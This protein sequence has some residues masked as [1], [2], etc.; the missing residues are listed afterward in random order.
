MED[1]ISKNQGVMTTNVNN[2][3]VT[4]DMLREWL[5]NGEPV[6]VLDIR[7]ADQRKEW[8]I[9]GSHYFDAYKRLNEGDYAVM[10]EIDIPA[11]TKV[12]TVCAAGRT[13]RIASELLKQ[14]GIEAYSLEG[15]MKKWSMAW[16]TAVR[17]FND[18][19]V[20]QVRRTGKGCLSYIISSK[21]EAVLLDASLPPDVYQHLIRKH[22]LTLKYVIETH[23]HADHLSRS[24]MLAEFYNVPL[25]LPVPNKVQ[26]DSIAATTDSVFNIGN[27]SIR[28]MPTPGHT[29]ESVSY[30]IGNE[31]IFTG[32]TLFID[33]V[34]RP[35]LKAENNNETRVRA[36]LLYKSLHEI[37]SLPGEMSIFPAHTSKAIPFDNNIITASINEVKEK[38]KLLHAREE[39]FVDGLVQKIP[40]TPPNYMS[41]VENNLSGDFSN[42]DAVELEA[43]AN[44]CAIS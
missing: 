11:K 26:F 42:V 1:K 31:A 6:F 17:K 43:G 33:G 12:V 41:I 14:K 15:G 7:T 22:G 3:T 21:N 4:A 28:T 36:S 8:Q 38:I 16:N 5:E 19:E 32:D 24:K 13:S 35:D 44:R 23:I 34:G 10:D 29:I 25:F 18:F 30:Y 9:P 2:S 20:L 40:A 27:I 37:V 39:D